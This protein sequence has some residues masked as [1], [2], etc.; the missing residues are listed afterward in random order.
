MIL[1]KN[2]IDVRFIYINY[3][4]IQL[5]FNIIDIIIKINI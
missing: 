3:N 4:I 1:I 2:K 5:K